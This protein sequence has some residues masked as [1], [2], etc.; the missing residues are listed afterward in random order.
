MQSGVLPEDFGHRLERLKEASGLSWRGLAKA[1]GVDPKQLRLWRKR[2]VEP[3][4]GAML[5]ICRFA[6]RLPGGL[7]ILIGEGFQMTF[8]KRLTGSHPASAQAQRRQGG[9]WRRHGG[10]PALAH[11]VGA[12]RPSRTPETRGPRPQERPLAITSM[13]D[14]EGKKRRKGSEEQPPEASPDNPLA[15]YTPEQQRMIPQR[16]AHLGQGRHPLLHA[17]ARGRIVPARGCRRT[18]ARRRMSAPPTLT[19]LSLGEDTL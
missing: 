15:S 17:Q 7:E 4:G 12:G 8:F 10:R 9:A 14:T 19:V 6:A 13:K 5:S 18:A 16:A 2:G 3:C 11:S 1:L